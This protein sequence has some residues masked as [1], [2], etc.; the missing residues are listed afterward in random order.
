MEHNPQYPLKC[1]LEHIRGDEQPLDE[2]MVKLFIGVFLSEKNALEQDMKKYMLWDKPPEEQLDRAVTQILQMSPVANILF[3][4]MAARAPKMLMTTQLFAWL[5]ANS[6][7]P[8]IAVMWVHAMYEV[9]LE[10][11]IDVPVSVMRWANH[12]PNGLPT[13]NFAHECWRSQKQRVQ[14]KGDNM[15]DDPDFWKW[16]QER[17][18]RPVTKAEDSASTPKV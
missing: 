4:H 8:G 10:D 1:L 15:L 13:E 12:F 11:A 9:W 6:D 16:M 7:R 17:R 3:N 2:N 14:G 5:S 18:D